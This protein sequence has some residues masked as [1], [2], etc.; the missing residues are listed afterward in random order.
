MRKHTANRSQRGMATM[1]VLI[2]GAVA[3]LLLVSC[4]EHLHALMRHTTQLESQ[5]GKEAHSLRIAVDPGGGM[6]R[7]RM[8]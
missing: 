8:D 4:F 2:V 3:F 5:V 6:G 7:Q 1:T